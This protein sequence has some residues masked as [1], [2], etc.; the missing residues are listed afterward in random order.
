MSKWFSYFTSPCQL[1]CS[2][3]QPAL[4]LRTRNSRKPYSSILVH[5]LHE[6]QA[7]KHL[8]LHIFSQPFPLDSFHLTP[9]PSTTT[10]EIFTRAVCLFILM[11]VMKW[12]HWTWSKVPPWARWLEALWAASVLVLAVYA[13]RHQIHR[14]H[15][16]MSP[17]AAQGELEMN[18]RAPPG[19]SR[20]LGVVPG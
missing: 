9:S 8:V 2:A 7:L 14:S 18:P 19:S 16:H 6:I 17:L 13:Y 15:Q 1:Y 12:S 20:L 5:L 11:K 3:K 10:W 4:N